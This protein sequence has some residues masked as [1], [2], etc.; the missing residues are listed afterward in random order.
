MNS[1]K[2]SVQ[3]RGRVG[4]GPL[5]YPQ[6]KDCVAVATEIKPLLEQPNVSTDSNKRTID[7][8]PQ[9]ELM[10][11]GD[12]ISSVGMSR[13]LPASCLLIRSS[14]L[15]EEQRYWKSMMSM[16]INGGICTRGTEVTRRLFL[17]AARQSV[18]LAIFG[19]AHP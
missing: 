15:V 19:W 14:G 18:Q 8:R 7:R 10:G 16:T 2:S 17:G 12:E 4:I 5:Y 6:S 1:V 11:T 13:L 3:G 9:G